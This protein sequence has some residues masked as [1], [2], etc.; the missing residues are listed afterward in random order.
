VITRIVISNKHTIASCTPR[1]RG[2]SHSLPGPRA[3]KVVETEHVARH[4][5]RSREGLWQVVS[6]PMTGWQM[7]GMM[8]FTKNSRSGL[9][10]SGA[11]LPGAGETI[12][13]GPHKGCR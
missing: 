9:W 8:L 5:T 3:E 4:H 12:C 13:P 7:G 10:R 1:L 6:R 11:C 2:K